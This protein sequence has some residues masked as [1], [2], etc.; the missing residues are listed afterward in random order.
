M[1]QPEATSASQ[2][3]L[4]QQIR[5][6]NSQSISNFQNDSD[7]DLITR[8]AL[9][10]SKCKS[11]AVA[12]IGDLLVKH[13]ISRTLG[14]LTTKLREKDIAIAKTAKSA[15]SVKVQKVQKVHCIG[16]Q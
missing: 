15:K 1:R 16:V 11:V 10:R 4:Q 5:K 12:E 9:A 13:R 2:P 6:N 14:Y 3:C 7:K 8:V